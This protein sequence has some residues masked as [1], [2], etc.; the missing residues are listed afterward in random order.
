[1]RPNTVPPGDPTRP[2]LRKLN[3]QMVP[4]SAQLELTVEQV[5][6]IFAVAE[7]EDVK[8]LRELAEHRGLIQHDNERTQDENGRFIASSST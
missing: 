8:I 3:Q 2:T 6:T 5:R 7:S 4:P 1:M